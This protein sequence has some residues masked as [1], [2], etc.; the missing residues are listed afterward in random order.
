MKFLKHHFYIDAGVNIAKLD[1][2]KTE[3][4]DNFKNE[5]IIKSELT[6][7]DEKVNNTKENKLV[8]SSEEV[9][10]LKNS[11][12]AKLLN[13][14]KEPLPINNEEIQLL[15]NSTNITDDVKINLKIMS[16]QNYMEKST[17]ESNL[18]TTNLLDHNKPTKKFINKRHSSVFTVTC[19]DSRITKLNNRRSLNIQSQD[20]S[21]IP[22]P[23]KSFKEF[24]GNKKEQKG[25]ENL[26]IKVKKTHKNIN[27]KKIDNIN[28]DKVLLITHEK[29]TENNV[30]QNSS[31]YNSKSSY[32]P[33]F[34]K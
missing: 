22:V 27:E 33:K 11:E 14:P 21:K 18:K 7:L 25:N 13:K 8:N 5:K 6:Q 19:D 34:I 17:S 2:I 32:L 12:K 16:E 10:H 4:I 15:N 24:E 23:I 9:R 26:N 30:N 28:N 31:R 29:I 3:K 20:M 1:Q